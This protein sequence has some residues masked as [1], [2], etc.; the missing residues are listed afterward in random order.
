MKPSG[1]CEAQIKAASLCQGFSLFQ[2]ALSGSIIIS[3]Q[4]FISFSLD[5]D[6]F[7]GRMQDLIADV[8][9]SASNTDRLV[10]YL[11]FY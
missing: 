6:E 4:T 8:F 5:V 9:R 7:A 10:P 11:I 3:E 1:L 2:I